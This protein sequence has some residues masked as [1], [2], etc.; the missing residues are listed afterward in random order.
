[1]TSI[2]LALA[3]LT[4]ALSLTLSPLS[5]TSYSTDQSDL[6]WIPGES[7]WGFQ[8]VQRGSVIFLTMF[9]YGPAGAPTWYVATLGPTSPGSFVWEGD[10][11][12]TN[13]PWFAAVPYDPA[14]FTVRKAGTMTWSPQTV[15]SGRLD[16]AVDGVAVT[17]NVVR[18]TL[19][20]D[21]YGG[22]YL[23]AFHDTTTGCADPINNVPP[24]NDPAVTITVTQ[25]GQSVGIVLSRIGWSIAIS[26]TLAQSG[27]FGSVSGTYMSSAGEVGTAN[28]SAMNV[29]TNSLTGSFALNS[30]SN[31][32]QNAGYF[33]GMRAS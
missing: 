1:M 15:T 14:L 31:G 26:G 32:C 2:R 17:K 3:A 9:V 22:T 21:N 7:G 24:S 28:V 16:Y 4:L 18:Q 23:G 13:G 19:V 10:L 5:A 33:S 6:W 12:A 25:N 27:Q 29:Q 8:I 20:A 11:Y 30:T